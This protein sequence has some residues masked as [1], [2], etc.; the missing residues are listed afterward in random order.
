[1]TITY[2]AC[3]IFHSNDRK[4]NEKRFNYCYKV[5][6]ECGLTCTCKICGWCRPELHLWGKKYQLLM[7]CFRNF[8]TVGVHGLLK[9]IFWN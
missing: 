7:Y 3:H 4:T 1:M 5:A 2:H 9:T 6:A 8:K